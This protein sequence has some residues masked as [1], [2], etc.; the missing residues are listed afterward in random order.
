MLWGSLDHRM[1][2]ALRVPDD[3]ANVPH[4]SQS[5]KTG[6]VGVLRGVANRAFPAFHSDPRQDSGNLTLL[7]LP[8]RLSQLDLQHLVCTRQGQGLG[9]K[10]NT[11]RAFVA[12]D[13][14]VAMGL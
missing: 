12:S 9:P 2:R 3:V 4:N 10:F 5:A 14:R 7:T 11:A 6:H 13:Q 8:E 1:A